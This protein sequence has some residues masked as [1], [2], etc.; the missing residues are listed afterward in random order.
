MA[1][2]CGCSRRMSSDTA[3]A[4][5][6]FSASRPLVERPMLIRSMML[7]A[8]SWPKASTSTLRRNSSAPTPTEV[9]LSTVSAKSEMTPC[10]SSRETL[11]SFAIALPMRCTSFAP[12]CLS[13][14]A[15]SL[16][17]SVSSRM[18][19]RSVPLR[20][21]SRLSARSLIGAYP[22]AHHLRDSLG[23]L[24]HERARL[25]ELLLVCERGHGCLFLTCG[26][27]G[28]ACRPAR[29]GRQRVRAGSPRRREAHRSD[30][31]FHQRPQHR[32]DQHEHHYEAGDDP[33]QA[34]GEG[35]LPER[36]RLEGAAVSDR[37]AA[38]IERLVQN[39]DAV[40]PRGI[41][42][43]GVLDEL[44]DSRELIRAQRHLGHFAARS[45][46]DTIADQHRDRQPPDGSGGLT[47]V[48]E[49]LVDLVVAR[50]VARNRLVTRP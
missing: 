7:A 10:T 13:T 29:R 34:P 48:I 39:A 11:A 15:A 3:R 45:G 5:I 18:A 33:Q 4:S 1:V 41:E 16:S 6:H 32:E 19:A 28:D 14:W 24:A 44:S 37:T 17:P 49:R 2:I 50:D 21:A 20:A 47:R 12:M 26:Q 9:W 35:C 46:Q 27:R 36:R 42:S 8:L 23:I 38:G 40:T 30:E 25:D 43:H 31:S 22:A